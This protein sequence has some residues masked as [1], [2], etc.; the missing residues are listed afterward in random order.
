MRPMHWFLSLSLC[1]TLSACPESLPIED[2]PGEQAKAQA[3]ASRYFEALVKGDQDTVL[4]LSVLPFWGD[5]DL[6]KERDVL[7]EEV[8]RQISSVKDQA[9]DVQVEG[10]HFMTLEQVRVVMPALYERIQEAD[11]A[12]TRLYVVALRVRLGENAEHGVILV[13]QDEDGLW[14]VMGIGD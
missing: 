3:A 14:K 5:G 1:L 13:R 10:S 11:L 4:M 12:D 9:F 8:S 6:I 7:T 2:D